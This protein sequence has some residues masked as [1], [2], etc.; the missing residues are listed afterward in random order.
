MNSVQTRS[1]RTFRQKQIPS[2]L[3]FLF[4][5]TQPASAATYGYTLPAPGA[6]FQWEVASTGGNTGRSQA[7]T[8]TGDL[9]LGYDSAN[10]NPSGYSPA[11][12]SASVTG[13]TMNLTAPTFSGYTEGQDFFLVDQ[14]YLVLGT[15]YSATNIF[16]NDGGAN[17]TVTG[18]DNGSF[19]VAANVTGIGAINVSA[20]D[21][22]T[23]NTTISL[24][25]VSIQGFDLSASSSVLLPTTLDA[26]YTVTGDASASRTLS[27]DPTTTSVAYGMS[28]DSSAQ[29]FGYIYY[30]G[31]TYVLDNAPAVPEPSA[32]LLAS[33]GAFG[34]LARRKR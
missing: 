23:I 3:L 32:A 21:S 22:N 19:T 29:V 26:G 30:Q 31:T 12:S 5:S 16:I 6:G 13:F 27:L 8:L 28:G 24:G 9:G 25:G 2:N 33:L 4:F 14:I 15:S 7:A 11:T 34:W 10:L 18:T 20:A 1:S 17:A